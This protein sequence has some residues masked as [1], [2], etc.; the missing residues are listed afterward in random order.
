MPFFNRIR[1]L[2]GAVAGAAAGFVYPPLCLLCRRPPDDPADRICAACI[3]G[4]KRAD[5]AHPVRREAQE[6]LAAGGA[7]DG[8]FPLFLFEKQGALQQAL[9]M[10]KYSG[11]HSVAVRLGRELGAEMMRVPEYAAAD[12]LLPVPLHPARLRERGYNQSEKICEGISRVT[13]MTVLDGALVRSRNTPS[14]TA[15]GLHEREENV[16][17]AFRVRPGRERCVGAGSVVLVDDV[18]TTGSTVLA[19]AAA[20]R[21]AGAEKVLAAAVAVADRSA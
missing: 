2:A 8:F 4:M 14:Q 1:S 12:V 15:L 21:D 5:D 9:H 19:C 11:M 13:G 18:L 7:V 17:G 6:R 10:M 16:R 20:L 3:G